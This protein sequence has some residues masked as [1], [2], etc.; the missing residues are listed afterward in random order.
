MDLTDRGVE[1]RDPPKPLDVF[2]TTERGIY[3]VGETVYATSLVR[4]ATANA[5][6]NVPLTAIVTRPDGK[7]DS[8]VALQDQGLGGTVTPVNLSANAMRGTWRIG[9]YSDVKGQPLAETTFLVEDF[10]PERLDFDIE[11]TATAI[12]RNAPA[13]LTI[14]ARFLYGAPAG[15]L[16][17]EGEAVLK[18]ARELAAYPGY[19]VRPRRRDIRRGGRAVLRHH[20]RRGRA[21]R[22]PGRASRRGADQPAADRGHQC[23]RARYE[24]PAGGAHQDAAGARQRRPCRHPPAVRWRRR[25][26]RSRRLRGDRARPERRAHRR[27]GPRL[28]ALRGARRTSSGTAPTAAGT[29]RS[30]RRRTGSPTARSMSPPTGRRASKRNVQWGTYRLEVTSATAAVLPASYDFEAGWYVQ[31]KALDTPEALKVSLDKELY[32][33]GEKARVHLETRFNGVALI[34]VVDDRLIAT[35]S[36]EVTGNAADIDLDVTR[37][38]GARRLCDRRPLPA[39]G[40]R[41]RSACPAARSGSPGPASI[42]PTATCRSSRSTRR[43]RCVRGRHLKSALTLANLPAGQ[44]GLCHARG[45]RS[46]HPEP[47]PLRDA[48][49]GEPTISASG[50]S[51]CRSATSTTS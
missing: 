17:I 6:E 28:V 34:M 37:A 14:D 8:R 7:E 39:D 45:R 29:T 40:H 24:R 2:L 51:A 30:S 38:V 18:G 21:R 25:R 4:D 16:N 11:T 5:V 27:P 26:E 3:R 50:G 43:T 20:D 31:A 15:N 42:R 35:K 49:S 1:G 48:R 10:E 23:P 12:D 47:H 13:P 32:A 36:V 44:R 19:C 33:V 9:V 46:R 22:D 41:R